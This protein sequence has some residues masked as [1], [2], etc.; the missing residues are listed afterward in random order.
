MRALDFIG[1]L[2]VAILIAVG[3]YRSLL[4]A[5]NHKPEDKTDGQ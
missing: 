2:V 1:G 4:W 3:I 5:F